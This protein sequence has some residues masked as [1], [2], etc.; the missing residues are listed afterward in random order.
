MSN[1]ELC[2]EGGVGEKGYEGDE[3]YKGDERR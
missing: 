3:G 2:D 1:S